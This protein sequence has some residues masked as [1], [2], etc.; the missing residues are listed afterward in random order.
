M[1]L[2]C[3]A[4]AAPL[5]ASI[6]AGTLG[7]VEVPAPARSSAR[8]DAS[9]LAPLYGL[10]LS[11]NERALLTKAPD[12]RLLAAVYAGTETTPSEWVIAL[13]GGG[14]APLL[15][16]ALR[17]W[18]QQRGFGPAPEPAPGPGLVALA[19]GDRQVFLFG[20]G[21]RLGVASTS[22]RA[23]GALTGVTRPLGS[24]PEYQRS[25]GAT[26]DLRA[27]LDVQRF[28]GRLA[29]S[30]QGRT[31]AGLVD[32]LG[33]LGVQSVDLGGAVEGPGAVLTAVVP[34]TGERKGLRQV[35]GAP[36]PPVRPG[37]VPPGAVGWARA[38]VCPECLWS[39]AQIV[40]SYEAPVETALVVANLA[41]LEERVGK[42]IGADVLGATPRPW[43]VYAGDLG[44]QTVSVLVAELA[45]AATGA[46]FVDELAAMLPSVFPGL[47]LRPLPGAGPR[48]W[49][50]FAQGRP[51]LA[52]ALDRG[53]LVLSA[54]PAAVRAHLRRRAGVDAS[55][56]APPAA[57]WGQLSPAGV[58][59][60]LRDTEA[61]LRV[62]GLAG[63]RGVGEAALTAA[64][65]VPS[66]ALTPDD[67]GYH[68]SLEV[69]QRR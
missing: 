11:R 63:Q 41:T 20:D 40:S 8:L 48:V 6:D 19:G 14:A 47:E 35:L 51:R 23:S 44:G 12:T 57:V 38:V 62:L 22:G 53:A 37:V 16:D 54:L 65:A 64:L 1:I 26:S 59:V 66:F 4:L 56:R 45:D 34:V 29:L 15:R 2:T 39:L 42:Q 58:R 13:D 10:L 36:V 60:L 52:F 5:E 17:G 7:W 49:T 3:L 28:Y 67:A 30:P 24:S 43:T 18:L 21:G 50:L 69:G 61:G 46:R 32:R 31:L 33:L 68:G 27:S 25:P 55:L 9:V